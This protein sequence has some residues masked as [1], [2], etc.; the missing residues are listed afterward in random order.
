MPKFRRTRAPE[1]QAR[2]IVG[3]LVNLG[4]LR[5]GPAPTASARTID[6]YR[7]CLLQIA[8]H[9]EK[10]GLELFDL[11]RKSAEDYLRTRSADLGK[12]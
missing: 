1:R 7:D 2:I 5:R 12:V 8:R 9:L 4:V 10:D 11:D 6:N 3:R